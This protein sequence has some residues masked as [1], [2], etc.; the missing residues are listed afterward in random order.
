M[1]NEDVE[2]CTDVYI[3]LD[4]TVRRSLSSSKTKINKYYYSE[5]KH[6][7]SINKTLTYNKSL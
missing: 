3:T 2:G 7:K 4:V 5:S 6:N 1:F